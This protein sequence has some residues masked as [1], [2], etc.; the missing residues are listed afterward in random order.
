MSLELKQFDTARP[1]RQTLIL[2]GAPIDLSQAGT[3]VYLNFKD[4]QRGTAWQRTATILDDGTAAL[5]GQVEYYPIAGGVDDDGAFELEWEIIFA[6]T[7]RET[8]PTNTR[9][10]LLI[11]P[12]IIPT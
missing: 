11:Y 1:I 3:V 12:A 9:V 7:T 4:V 8:V 6:D 5:R 10:S 2:A